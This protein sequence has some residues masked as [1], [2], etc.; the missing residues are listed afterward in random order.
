MVH[1][2]Y[3]NPLF[4]LVNAHVWSSLMMVVPEKVV[5]HSLR[6]SAPINYMY[7]SQQSSVLGSDRK[8][9]FGSMARKNNLTS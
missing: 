9:E 3:C 5:G 7:A 4:R 1:I 6:N 8:D 2:L